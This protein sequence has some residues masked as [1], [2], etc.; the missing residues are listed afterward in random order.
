MSDTIE[1]SKDGIKLPY[2]RYLSDSTPGFILILLSI[3]AYY[4]NKLDFLTDF[5]PKSALPEVKLF[6][7]LLLFLLATPVGVIINATG[8]LIL[9]KP[10]KWLEKMI[11][12]EEIL[13]RFNEEYALEECKKKFG[14]NNDGNNWF[15]RVR[16]LEIALVKDF[17]GK[18]DGIEAIRGIA[19]LL[20]NLS[21]MLLIA[22]F[23]CA[24]SCLKST[25]PISLVCVMLHTPIIMFVLLLALV[26]L[27]LSAFVSFYFHVQIVRWSDILSDD[28]NA[29]LIKKV[30]E[31]V[32]KE[33]V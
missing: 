17:P 23:I 20:R 16:T 9:E 19:I 6:V 5:L 25:C 30:I 28:E 29:K 32:P 4:N 33:K 3:G 8:W 11:Y 18:S 15:E 31:K 1:L 27:C 10:Q 24:D 2:R 14:I 21:L 13:K 26:F 22:F 7:L 12:T